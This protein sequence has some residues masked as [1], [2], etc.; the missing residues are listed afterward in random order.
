MPKRED[1]L[2]WRLV[3]QSMDLEDQR[4][5]LFVKHHGSLG[6]GRETILRKFLTDQTPEPYRVSTGFVAIMAAGGITSDQCDV[7]VYDPRVRQPFYRIDQF[8]VVPPDC[9]RLAIEVRTSMDLSTDGGLAQVFKV[10]GSMRPYF[11]TQVFGFGFDGP[12]FDTFVAGMAEAAKADPASAQE[13]VA[14]HGRNYVCIRVES[15]TAQPPDKEFYLAIDFGPLGEDALGY[16]TAFFMYCYHRRIQDFVS[17]D[18]AIITIYARDWGVPRG[19]LRV[20]RQEGT[21]EQGFDPDKRS[22]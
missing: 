3:S 7:L 17:F 20:I 13:C 19:R 1:P 18:P 12:L 4:L 10:N 14:V 9:C 8:V 16:A 6:T 2:Y 11:P 21:I 5:R 22:T 15:R